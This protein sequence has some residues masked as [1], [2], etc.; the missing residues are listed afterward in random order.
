MPI[1]PSP[2]TWLH[3]RTIHVDA[4]E[5]ESDLLLIG[6]LHDE[7][8]SLPTESTPPDRFERKTVHQMELRVRV[9]TATN[10]ITDAQARMHDFPHTECPAITD[11]FSQ[12]VGLQ[13]GP[14]Y[15]RAVGELFSGPAGCTHLDHLARVIGPVLVQAQGSLSWRHIANG[16]LEP[17]REPPDSIRDTCHVWQTGGP[18]EAK[19]NLGWRATAPS[20]RVPP[21]S[22]FRQRHP[23]EARAD[24]EEE[25]QR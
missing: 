23:D 25:P 24:L 19:L 2:D 14:G 16:E 9:D 15:N 18:A 8:V 7:R 13:I 3:R 22:Y 12:L 17:P 21:V 1:E 11:A 4:F 10:T 5:D 20:G 6:H